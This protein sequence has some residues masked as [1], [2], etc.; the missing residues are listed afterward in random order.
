[1]SSPAKHRNLRWSVTAAV[2]AALATAALIWVSRAPSEASVP[3]PREVARA[4]AEPPAAR[5]EAA[6]ARR[7]DLPVR[8]EATGYLEPWRKV[9]VRADLAGRVTHRAVEEGGAVAAGGLLVRLDDREHLV[10]LEEARAELLKSQAFYAVNY[11]QPA[12]RQVRPAPAAVPDDV[13]R[14]EKLVEDGLL[15]RRSLDEVR[16]RYEADGL[17]SGSRQGEVRAVTSGVVQAEQRVERSRLALERTRILAPFAGRVA[18]LAVEAGQQIGPGDALMTLLQDDRLKVDVDVLE[19]DIVRIR[20]GAPARVRIPSAGGLVL[21]GTVHT[22]NPRIDPETGTGR[23]TVAIPNSRRLLLTGLFA[24]VEL[25]AERLADR[26]VVPASALLVRQGRDLVF[27][28]DG[29]RAVWTYVQV[30]RK[31]G[32]FAEILDG[33]SPGDAVATGGHFSLAHA[34]PVEAV[35]PEE[36]SAT[37]P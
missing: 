13:L 10:A 9:E 22:I 21:E 7:A 8:V 27:R 29:G 35:I 19:A 12:P 11:E 30:G 20:K 36:A 23:V 31:A 2:A 26:L 1:M 18:D 28:I 24:A 3:A 33:L 5:V 14:L 16:R 6:R 17:L 32:G 4:A 25:E 37:L 15:P 34:A